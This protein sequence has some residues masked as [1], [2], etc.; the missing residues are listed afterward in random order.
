[1]VKVHILGGPGSGKTTLAA[2][3]A[4]RFHVPHHDLDQLG[5]KHGMGPLSA[6]VEEALAIIKQPGWVTEGIYLYWTDPLLYEADYIVLLDIPLRVAIWRVLYRHVSKGLRGTNPYATKW[7]IPLFKGMIH[8]Y[9]RTEI[10]PTEFVRTYLE[11]YRELTAIPAS[12]FTEEFAL[13]YLEMYQELS[14]PPTEEFIKN[15]RETYKDGVEPPPL[16]FLRM[17]HDAFR[18]ATEPKQTLNFTLK[19]LE[20]YKEKIYVIKNKAERE[21]LFDLLAALPDESKQV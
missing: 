11:I 19:Y 21:R 2:E 13:R 15:Y 12:G 1:M 6:Y 5:W 9:D 20:K 7:L 10:P 18:E 8:M 3:I 14:A 4:A 17:H 16:A